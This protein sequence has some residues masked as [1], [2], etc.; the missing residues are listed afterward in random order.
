MA[1][2]VSP[3]EQ[4]RYAADGVSLGGPVITAA[5]RCLMRAAADDYDMVESLNSRADPDGTSAVCASWVGY[6]AA[7]ARAVL[8]EEGVHPAVTTEGEETP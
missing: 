2:G 5:L 4:L 3:A 1:A 7:I 8:E 6:T